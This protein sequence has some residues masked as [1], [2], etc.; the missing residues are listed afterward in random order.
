[1]TLGRH[2]AS[3]AALATAA[4]GQAGGKLTARELFHGSA[5]PA[6]SKQAAAAPRPEPP[7]RAAALLV[8]AGTTAPLGLRYSILKE[9]RGAAPIEVD[10]DT[11]FRSGYRIRLG[12]QTNSD[13]YLYVV[14]QGSSGNWTVLFP[15]PDVA[16]GD[17]L[18]RRG[19]RS[20]IPSGHWFAFD[21][22][23]GEEK[24]F[25]VLSRQPEPDLEKLIYAVQEGP[26]R[27]ETPPKMLLAL[28][29]PSI[30]DALIGRLR[31]QGYARDLIFEKVT[32][33]PASAKPADAEPE[34][35]VYVVNPA[36]GEQ[37]RVIVDLALNHR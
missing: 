13:A 29:P 1:M 8:A 3:L 26:R 31:E 11:V 5:E 20:E 14:A 30:S 10:P 37:A 18:V 19:A 28:N 34:K 23:A 7:K 33:K 2:L 6:P 15:T 16:G 22:Q 32:E 17:N 36:G 24:L 25:L 12:I 35:A 21:E 27:P 9:A 4:W